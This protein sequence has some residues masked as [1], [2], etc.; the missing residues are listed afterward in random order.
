MTLQN[1]IWLQN[2][3]PKF[4]HD[5]DHIYEHLMKQMNIIVAGANFT[6]KTIKNLCI[7]N[8]M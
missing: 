5:P 1:G 2:R 8:R 4:H 6:E 3:R 7:E